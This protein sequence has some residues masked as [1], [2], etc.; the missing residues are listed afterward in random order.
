MEKTSENIV[1]E[2]AIVKFFGPFIELFT[3]LFSAH[4]HIWIQKKLIWFCNYR[5]PVSSHS[6]LAKMHCHEIFYH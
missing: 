6:I 1:E 4:M 2:G 5:T 3:E